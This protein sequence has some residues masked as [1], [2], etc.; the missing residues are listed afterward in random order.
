LAVK[1]DKSANTGDHSLSSAVAVGD[2]SEGLLGYNVYRRAY[3]K[4]PAGQNTAAAGTWTMINP[5][6]VPDLFYTDMNLSNLVTNCYE[7][8]VTAKYDEVESDPSNIDWECIFVS[9]DPNE[10]NSV[11]VYPNPATNYVIVE[12]TKA[13][14]SISIYNSLG[15]VVAQKSVKGETS[16]NINTTNYAAGAYSVKFT[17]T[18]GE[19]FNRKFVVTK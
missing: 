16:F 19:T 8:Y 12:L 18:N 7:Y 15:S 2:N 6:I 5:A 9:V 14:S 13:V 10:A 11:S 3:A 17:T 4:F 1:A